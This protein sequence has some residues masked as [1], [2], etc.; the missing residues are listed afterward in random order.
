MWEA[1]EQTE[2]LGAQLFAMVQWHTGKQG[3][4]RQKKHNK[5]K[6]PVKLN[7]RLEQRFLASLL[8]KVFGAPLF[9]QSPTHP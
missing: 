2:L 3:H 9:Q 6:K 4:K 7:R 1:P 8:K 5:K